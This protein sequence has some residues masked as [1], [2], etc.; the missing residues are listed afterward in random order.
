MLTP[1]SRIMRLPSALTAEVDKEL[2]M[3]DVRSGYYFSLD[4]I[5]A[6]I[7][8]R[9][10]QPVE[11]DGLCSALCERYEADIDTIR[12]DVLALFNRM[13]ERGLLVVAD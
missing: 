12:R 3:M 7:W 6:D 10:A 1:Q 11:I 13:A 2:V 4:P 8:T 9:I 5:G